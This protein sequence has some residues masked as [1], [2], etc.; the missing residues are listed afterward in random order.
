MIQC[1]QPFD[2][3][4]HFKRFT[5]VDLLLSAYMYLLQGDSPVPGEHGVTDDGK[6]ELLP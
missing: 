2:L 5:I 3:Y 6:S 4:I 1:I